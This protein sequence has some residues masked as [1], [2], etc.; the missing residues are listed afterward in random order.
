MCVVLLHCL[1]ELVCVSLDSVVCIHN[2]LHLCVLSI[3]DKMYS[4]SQAGPRLPEPPYTNYMLNC[5]D[6]HYL[7]YDV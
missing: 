2:I 7:N 6:H 5:D 4:F 1:C 3:K